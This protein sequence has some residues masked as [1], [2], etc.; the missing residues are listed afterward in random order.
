MPAL[1][2]NWPVREFVLTPDR[3]EIALV[4]GDRK[5]VPPP[6]FTIEKAEADWPLPPAREVARVR[7]P[8]VQRFMTGRSFVW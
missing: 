7:S 6:A 8:N 5:S 4:G 1:S 3:P 2:E